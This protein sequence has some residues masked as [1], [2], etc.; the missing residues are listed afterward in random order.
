MK[1]ISWFANVLWSPW[2]VVVLVLMN[3]WACILMKRDKKKAEKHRQRIA[4]KT[5]F[6]A[7]ALYGGIGAWIGMYR[8]H[9]KT[10]H[11]YFVIGI[12]EIGRAHV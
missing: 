1:I 10:K 12:P 7:T 4:E 11:W 9:H 2:T 5:L 8:Y 3:L 6:L